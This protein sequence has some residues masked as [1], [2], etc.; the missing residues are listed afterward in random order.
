MAFETPKATTTLPAVWP[1]LWKLPKQCR[2]LEVTQTAPPTGDQMYN[3]LACEA[4]SHS[5]H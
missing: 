2:Q 3:P 5:N 4:H 1:H